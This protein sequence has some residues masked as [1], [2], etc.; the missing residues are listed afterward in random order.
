[1]KPLRKTIVGIF[2][3]AMLAAQPASAAYDWSIS[4]HVTCMEPTRMPAVLYFKADTA[5]GVANAELDN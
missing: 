4:A 1:M 2:A 3:V 5:G